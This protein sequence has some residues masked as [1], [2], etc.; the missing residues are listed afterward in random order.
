MNRSMSTTFRRVSTGSALMSSG[1]HSAASAALQ[2]S[3]TSSRSRH[4]AQ[5]TLGCRKRPW[6]QGHLPLA[7]SPQRLLF[8]ALYFPHIGQGSGGLA[9]EGVDRLLE[10]RH[11]EHIAAC[12]D[13]DRSQVGQEFFT[14]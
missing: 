3:A 14:A 4:R 5:E 7:Q 2:K 1:V 12:G 6:H 8:G 11:L 13:F 9:F 10:S